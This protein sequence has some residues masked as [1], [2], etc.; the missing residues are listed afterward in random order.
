MQ[1]GATD[2]VRLDQAGAIGLVVIDNPPV[3]A[4]SP[5]VRAGLKSCF[6]Q[7]AKD[8]GIEAVVLLCDGRT[9]CAGADLEELGGRV[10]EP[11][12]HEL[13][14][15]IESL[16]KPVVA[17]LH[18]TA[19]GGGVELSL[20]C[21]YRVA[22]NGAQVGFPEI[23][24]GLV[25]GAGGTQ[26]LPRLI[27]AGAALDLM[28]SG[29]PIAAEEALAL[30]LIDAIADGDLKSFAVSFVR[31]VA[32]QGHEPRRVSA[33]DIAPDTEVEALLF[34]RREQLASS[35][36]NR[37]V[38]AMVVDA[39]DAAV[40]LPFEAGLEQ[41]RAISDASLRTPESHALR[42]LFFAERQAAKVP[43]IDAGSARSIGSAAVV[44]GGTMG[45]GIAIAFATAGIPVTVSEVDSAALDACMSALR[46]HYESR[47]ARGR[48][49][50]AA[51]HEHAGL[52][53]GCTGFEALSDADLV[54]EAVFE[55]MNL[56]RDVFRRLDRACKPGAILATNTST[57]DVLEIAQE[58]SRPQDVVGLH[59]FSPANVM[60]LLEVVRTEQTAD[61]VVATAMA[62]ASR[63]KKIPVLSA[64]RYG[65]IGNR[66]MEPYGR[67]AERMLLEGATPAE[68]DG[69]LEEFGMA[70]GIL[71]VYD[72]AGVD[73]GTKTRLE[74]KEHLPD[75][76]SFY[77]ASALLVEA[78]M[79]GQKTG[80]GFYR[81]A[82]G[83]RERAPNPRAQALFAEEAKRLGLRPRKIS[84]EEIR[85]RC[86]CALINE[87][88]RV[89]GEGVAQRASDI[90]VVY[91][92]GYGF[93]R[94]RGGPMFHA[95]SLGLERVCGLIEGFARTLDSRYWEVAPLLRALA[96][97]GK[98]IADY[99]NA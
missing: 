29:R 46:S 68:I 98:T 61:D 60:R 2:I 59:F 54:I 23:N 11:G 67:E 77:R 10:A 28:L 73:V 9:F 31:R 62:L 27:G 30:G 48:M 72:M 87:G 99:S 95:D 22:A 36:P 1:G 57:L 18:G 6:D 84:A 52:I 4:I 24:L 89:L 93:P 80:E 78:G 74:R 55:S 3:N 33:E 7:A 69:A 16:D 43:G 37:V 35:F 19:L 17:A 91:A 90:D 32:A 82:E 20:A 45:R 49:T 81:Y 47:A 50:Q 92:A 64:N 38:P 21:H 51:A 65:F 39:V 76:P 44:G 97:E 26:R 79:L 53:S 71:A 40:H 8:S 14:R 58:T 85:Q 12:Y 15:D 63:L 34:E 66:M 86:L 5:Q 88:A 96:T 70:M 41:E 25:P 13:F 56:K 94:Y 42:R 83:S 75:D